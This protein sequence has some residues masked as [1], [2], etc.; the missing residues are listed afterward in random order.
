MPRI[1][2]AENVFVLHDLSKPV[3]KACWID[4]HTMYKLKMLINSQVIS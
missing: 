3:E 2:Y 1:L 4:A